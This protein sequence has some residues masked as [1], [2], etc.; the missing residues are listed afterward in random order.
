[1][2][3]ISLS[4]FRQ[5]FLSKRYISLL[6]LF[7]LISLLFT[8]F[9]RFHLKQ[10][11][12]LHY[13]LQLAEY[14]NGAHELDNAQYP[15]YPLWGYPLVLSSIG[16]YEHV[17]YYQAIFGG[18]LLYFFYMYINNALA[19][20]RS[21]VIWLI[22]SLAAIPYYAVISVKWPASF[23]LPFLLC[24]IMLLISSFEKA[25]ILLSILAALFL[26]VSCNFRSEYLY[27]PLFIL[28]I[29]ILSNLLKLYNANRKRYLL[30]LVYLV[31]TWVAMIPLGIERYNRTGSFNTK[32]GNGDWINVFFSIGQYPGNSLSLIC[33]DGWVEQYLRSNVSGHFDSSQ[34]L[35][36][37]SIANEYCRQA[38]IEYI[39]DN[40][41][42]YIGK[43]MHNMRAIAQGGF[44]YG[45]I[46]NTIS[47]RMHDNVILVK[48]YYK[49]IIG[50]S[51]YSNNLAMLY[52]KGIIENAS[53]VSLSDISFITFIFVS[54]FLLINM[55]LLL[56]YWLFLIL[57]LIRIYSIVKYKIMFRHI[58]ILLLIP[59]VYGHLLMILG[60]YENRFAS[61]LYMFIIA[62]L[63]LQFDTISLFAKHLSIVKQ[64][65]RIFRKR[66]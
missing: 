53:V 17:I 1:M 64:V 62:F 43:L 58:E 33:E 3:N 45:E 52:D 38:F 15:L 66:Q 10:Q 4:T 36:M 37:Q 18:I 12:A 25:S 39:L 57:L 55:T 48:E 23:Q 34:P 40:P 6:L 44:Y 5:S 19:K 7:I 26:G 46:E 9:N 11:G 51:N 29:V 42:N 32:V 56:I 49:S 50:V 59:I 16:N 54:P 28:L 41:L 20:H 13:H 21:K 31:F 63:V 22:L 60:L 35:H 27:L 65:S 61:I 24:S 30:V 8:Y 14:Y 2:E 47:E